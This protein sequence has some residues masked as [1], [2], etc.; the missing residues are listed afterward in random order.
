MKIHLV[1]LHGLKKRLWIIT[2]KD[3]VKLF[4]V[5]IN[6]DDLGAFIKNHNGK[7]RCFKFEVIEE[8]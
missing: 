2:I 1:Y 8:V 5:K 6:I 7:L 3:D 4:K